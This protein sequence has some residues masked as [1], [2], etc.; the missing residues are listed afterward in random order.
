MYNYASYLAYDAKILK[1]VEEL[2]LGNKETFLIS[3]I[4]VQ[5]QERYPARTA[6]DLRSVQAI[7]CDAKTPGGITN[8]STKQT[9]L[10]KWRK[11]RYST[12]NIHVTFQGMIT[13]EIILAETIF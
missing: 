7:N 1:N 12:R 9:P 11:S 3:G 13:K 10:Y 2:Y 5:A 6:I 8:F 4:S